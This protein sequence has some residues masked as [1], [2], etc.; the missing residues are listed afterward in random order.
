LQPVL[1]MSQRAR[2]MSGADFHS[3]LPVSETKDELADLA[4][5]FNKVLDSQHRAYE[6]QRRFT[7]NAAHEL[8]TPLTVLLGQIDV[9]LRRTRSPEEYAKTVRVL[10]DQTAQLQ[11]IVDS[12]L[13][14]ARAEDDAV[15]PDA[16][17]ISLS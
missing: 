8:R 4:M 10:R 7:D 17:A 3:R 5:S 1:D 6:Q 15:L 12:L 11:T 13:F 16:E 2:S 9:A 14:L